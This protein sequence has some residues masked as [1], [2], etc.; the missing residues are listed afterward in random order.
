[1]AEGGLKVAVSVPPVVT[2]KPAILGV[3][4]QSYLRLPEPAAGAPFKTSEPPHGAVV[5]ADA[6]GMTVCGICNDVIA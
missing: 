1:M 5:T 4:P 2:V 6:A 3:P